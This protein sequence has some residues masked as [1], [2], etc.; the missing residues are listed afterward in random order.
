[1]RQ[2]SRYQVATAIAVLFHTVGLVGLLFFKETNFV[3]TTPLHLSLM[4][5]LLFYT[6]EKINGPFIIFFAAC[7]ITGIAV[8]IIGTSTG[9]LFGNYSYGT[10]LGP[11]YKNVPYIIGVNWFIIIYCCGVAV[12]SLLKKVSDKMSE[13][14]ERPLKKIKALSIVVDG[15]TLAVAF[16]WLI[17]PVAIKLGYWAWLGDG[18][19]PMFNYISWF[20]ISMLL[21]LIFHYGPFKKQNKFAINLLLIQAMFF[22]L[23]RT[24][25]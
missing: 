1:M 9:Y 6:Q 7:F 24:F 8:E 5:V 23:L 3:N 15:A 14:M 2:F 12:H 10:V 20:V 16:D 22:L 13:E 11:G 25:L 18:Q 19:I 21:L 4:A 17:E